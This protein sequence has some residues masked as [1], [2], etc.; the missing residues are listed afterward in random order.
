VL[1]LEPNR[2]EF[3][4]NF[5][6]FGV[7]VRVHP[8]F[9]ALSAFLGWS[10]VDIGLQYLALWIGCV[11][12][13]ILI[14]ELGHVGM[15]RLFG[16]DG[17]I[18]LYSFGGLA[19]GSSGLPNRWQR[20]A[21]YFAGPLAGFLY[22]AILVFGLFAVAPDQFALLVNKAKFQLGL[23]LTGLSP[24]G[25]EVVR[26]SLWRPTLSEAVV[27]DLA[28]INLFWGLLNLLPVWPLDGGQISRDYLGWLVP[29]KGLRLSL[30]ISFVVAGVLA[31]HALMADQDMPLLPFLSMLQGIYPAVLFGLL[32][33]QSFQLLHQ[34]TANRR[35]WDNGST[36]W[37]RDPDLWR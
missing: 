13:S 23:P 21:V 6:I 14:H 19:V 37:E 36:P 34:A 11:F 5:R 32:A 7:S 20:I 26:I 1:L 25:V 31:V 29:G 35:Y 22:L 30:G 8:M 17:H 3:D 12:V 10:Y 28:W 33:V 4:L 15:G 9:W 27:Y 16:T 18:I 24:E 2:T